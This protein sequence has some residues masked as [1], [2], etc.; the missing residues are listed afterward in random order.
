MPLPKPKANEKQSDF[1][2]RCITDPN[3]QKEGKT[4]EQRLGIC[5]AIYKEN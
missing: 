2:H 3:V 5:Y 4:Q 1:I